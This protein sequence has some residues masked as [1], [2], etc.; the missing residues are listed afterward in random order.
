MLTQKVKITNPKIDQDIS[1]M[2]KKWGH[3]ICS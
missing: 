1:R 2:S 3:E